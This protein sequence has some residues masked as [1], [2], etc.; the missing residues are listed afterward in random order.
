MI[1]SVGATTEGDIHILLTE[2]LDKL[3]ENYMVSNRKLID[4]LQLELPLKSKQGLSI[5]AKSFK[6]L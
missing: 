6:N 2:R 4:A 3:T 5:T 1:Q